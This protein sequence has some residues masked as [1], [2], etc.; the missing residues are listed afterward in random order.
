MLS[1]KAQAKGVQL[2]STVE[3]GLPASVEGDGGRLRQILVNL[4]DNAI[5][6]TD[7]GEINLE[8]QIAGNTQSRLL[9]FAVHDTGIGI[10][11]RDQHKLFTKFTQLTRPGAI[12]PD[13]TGLGLA[14]SGHLV[15][16]MN[17]QISVHSEPGKGSCFW[18]EIPLVPISSGPADSAETR[19][20]VDQAAP[21][22][23]QFL[24][25]APVTQSHPAARILLA[26]DNLA[27]QVVTTAL[28][29]G[30]GY[31]IDTVINGREAVAAIQ[32]KPYDLVLMDISMGEMN[33]MDA[34]AA[35]RQ[36]SGERGT[37]PIVAMTA[38]AIKGDREKFLAA[39]MDDYLSKP[40]NKQ[41]LLQ[42]LDKWIV[43][44]PEQ[45]DP[46]TATAQPV[47]PS[48]AL[49]LATLEQLAHDT[50]PAAL[51]I[52]IA[53]FRK[54]SASR[55]QAISQHLAP[56]AMEP[57]QREAHSLKSSAGTFGAYTLQQLAQ[58]L[59]LACRNGQALIAEEAARKI[60]AAWSEVT[61]ELDRYGSDT[62]S[63]DRKTLN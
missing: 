7:E 53:A 37:I 22:V 39:G 8:V 25:S 38:H 15:D 48:P 31:H 49:D 2:I 9:R 33:G 59:E 3:N 12:P 5:K 40:I 17:G 56:L 11:A 58:E 52:L 28:L 18:F 47:Q 13:G 45:E 54:D 62:D 19:S 42:T 41:L 44:C 60:P 29:K 55:V 20:M 36:L 16:L 51:P 46:T 57:L 21:A 4:I 23:Q 26:E 32:D 61:I 35:I 1:P 6:F 24:Q 27:N 10:Q 34:T 14:I 63:Q 30:T 50:S 43:R